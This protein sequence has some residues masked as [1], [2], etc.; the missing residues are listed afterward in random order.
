MVMMIAREGVRHTADSAFFSRLAWHG[1]RTAYSEGEVSKVREDESRQAE[2]KD[3]LLLLWCR[4]HKTRKTR[5][6]FV[7]HPRKTPVMAMP[8]RFEF[9]GATTKFGRACANT[10]RHLFTAPSFRATYSGYS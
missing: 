4:G 7:V 3:L 2:M 6:L 1:E 5:N 8:I 9:Y 10:E